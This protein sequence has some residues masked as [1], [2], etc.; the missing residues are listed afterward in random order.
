MAYF[1]DSYAIIETIKDN[2]NYENFKDQPI[3]TNALNISEVYYHILLNTGE[4]TANKMIESLDIQE[5]AISK[6]ISINAAKFRH[7]HKK[8]KLSYADCIGYISAKTYNL[9]FLTGDKEFEHLDNVE[10]V[11]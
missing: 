7:K 1:F 9:K 3:V 2:P 10:F 5:I 11:K 6:D 8:A 4:S